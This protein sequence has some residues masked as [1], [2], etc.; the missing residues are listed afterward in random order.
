[1]NDLDPEALADPTVII[2]RKPHLEDMRGSEGGGDP[3]R[4]TLEGGDPEARTRRRKT[5]L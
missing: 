5:D 1:M 3:C 2:P 4:Q